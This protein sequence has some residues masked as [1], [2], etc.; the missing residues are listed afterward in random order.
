MEA[1]DRSFHDIT[2]G[3]EFH[4]EYQIT[5]EVYRCFLAA[6]NDGNPLHVDEE[7]ARSQGFAGRVMHGG[8]L[9]GFVS[10]FIGMEFPGRR[11]LL[12]SCDMHFLTPSYLGDQ[13]RITARVSQ[14]VESQRA[15]VLV[16][17]LS[18]TTQSTCAAKASVHV[19][20]M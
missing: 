4:G 12:L 6:F 18:N 15:L 11:A 14:K 2:E 7:Y 17:M 10:H 1:R 5:A 3:Q 16:L 13:I 20:V 9:S 8:I 19:R